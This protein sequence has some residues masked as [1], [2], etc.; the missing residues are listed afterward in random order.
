MEDILI[1]SI[2]GRH[3][4]FDFFFPSRGHVDIAAFYPKLHLT[5]FQTHNTPSTKISKRCADLER[6]ERFRAKGLEGH[7]SWPLP[8]ASRLSLHQYDAFCL[9]A[10]LAGGAQSLSFRMKKRRG[11]G[12]QGGERLLQLFSPASFQKTS[13]LGHDFRILIICCVCIYETIPR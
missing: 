5:S 11:G 7:F 12:G 1:P 2:E 10:P 13:P 9:N 4:G 8:I 3:A 6:G